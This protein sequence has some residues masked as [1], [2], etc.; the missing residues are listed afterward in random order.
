MV[1]DTQR[2]TNFERRTKSTQFDVNSSSKCCESCL[3]CLF[4]FQNCEHS[5][6]KV[7]M[8]QVQVCPF[9]QLT[10]K[11]MSQKS[12]LLLRQSFMNEKWYKIPF[13][14]IKF[15]LFCI[16]MSCSHIVP[17]WWNKFTLRTLQL[18]SIFVDSISHTD[19]VLLL[20]IFIPK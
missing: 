10:V 11:W 6:E 18:R 14:K 8:R 7:Y 9:K 17:A 16:C 20:L 2:T 4:Y 3:S 1:Q 13:S 12:F 19:Y 15:F 5:K